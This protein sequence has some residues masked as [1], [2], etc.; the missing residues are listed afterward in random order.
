MRQVSDIFSWFLCTSLVLLVS[1]GFLPQ[2]EGVSSSS[3]LYIGTP[4]ESSFEKEV[5]PSFKVLKPRGCVI[6]RV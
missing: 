6:L 4:W 5:F 2:H 1:R 3:I